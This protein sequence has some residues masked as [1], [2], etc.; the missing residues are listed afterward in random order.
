MKLFLLLITV[1]T[2]NAVVFNCVSSSRTYFSTSFPTC[3]AS[4][5]PTSF[6]HLE[7]I[8]S[9]STETVFSALAIIRQNLD[10]IPRG[11]G[12]FFV[13]L[14]I[15]DLEDVFL[16]SISAK[17]LEGLPNLQ[18]LSITGAELTN[19]NGN[20]FKFTPKLEELRIVSIP[21]AHIEENLV[22]NLEVLSMLEIKG[23]CINFTATTQN[24]VD[25]YATRLPVDCPPLGELIPLEPATCACDEKIENLKS[26]MKQLKDHENTEIEKLQVK[27]KDLKDHE[28][29][30]NE[31]LQLKIQ[32]LKDHENAEI[33]KLQAKIKQQKTENDNLSD[34]MKAIQKRLHAVEKQQ[35]GTNS[36][37][38]RIYKLA[39]SLFESAA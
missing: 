22:V 35:S 15:L 6:S 3:S 27:I 12:N 10:V 14:I 19:L 5:S 2:A 24:M 33:E 36:H 1:A 32:Q 38:A 25:Y 28:K 13:N 29:T 8:T 37:L 20:L 26:E 7:N 21:L 9:D 18:Y 30:E 39:S 17:D 23:R 11:I 16:T 34:E 31:K 4:V